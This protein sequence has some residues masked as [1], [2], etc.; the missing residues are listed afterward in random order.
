MQ[1]VSANGI[2]AEA[3]PISPH[4]HT[5]ASAGRRRGSLAL[6]RSIFIPP[7]H[8]STAWR[9][10]RALIALGLGCRL[11]LLPFPGEAEAARVRPEATLP[12]LDP[13][14][15]AF[16]ATNLVDFSPALDPPAGKHGFMFVGSDGRFYFEDGTRGRFWGINVAKDA[17]FVPKEVIDQVAP[18][19]AAAGFNLVR[20]HHVDGITGLLP[21]DRASS[22]D[23]IDPAK[24]DL[25]HY[26]VHALKERG[27]YVYLDL[28]DFRTFQE[29]EGVPHAAELGRGAKPAALFNERL[30]ELQMAYARELLFG[31][32][33]PYTGVALGADPAVVMVEL[34]DENGLFATAPRWAE[35][36][37]PYWTELKR[38]WSFWLRQTYGTT[39]AL[40]RAWVGPDG[41]SALEHGEQLEDS[42]VRLIGPTPPELDFPSPMGGGLSGLA[43]AA[44]QRDVTRFCH[45]VHREYF[46][47]MRHALAQSGLRAPLTA[48]TDWEHPADLRAVVDEL[49]FVGC[50]WYYDH[51]IFAAGRAWHLPSFFTNASPI[52]DQAGL[53]FTSSV[54]KAAAAGKPLVVREWG[55]CWPN[56]LRGAGLVEAAACAAFQDIDALV[57]F[58]YNTDPETR[59]IEYFDVSS[60]PVR[61]GL[62][63]AAGALYRERRVRPAARRAAIA[64][65]REDSFAAPSSSLD[66]L[67]RLGWLSRVRQHLFDDVYSAEGYDVVVAPVQGGRAA[68]PGRRVV[69]HVSR[70]QG[71]EAAATLSLSGYSVAPRLAAEQRFVFDGLVY[72]A[73]HALALAPGLRFATEQLHNAGYEAV[74]VGEDGGLACGFFDP[75]RENCVLADVGAATVLR[76]AA[77]LAAGLNGGGVLRPAHGAFDREEFV[78]DTGEVTRLIKDEQ[79]ILN[80]PRVKAVAG[81]LGGGKLPTSDL[82]INS[83]APL[84]VVIALSLD[85]RP[86]LDSEAFLLKMVTVAANKG[87]K[88]SVRDAPPGSPQLK[89]EAFGT[90]PVDTKGRPASDPTTVRLDGEL[91]LSAYQA[92]GT[93]EAV[94]AGQLWYLW[95]DTPGARF[96]LAGL[97]GAVRVVPFGKSGPGEALSTAQPFVYPADC[98]FVRVG[99]SAP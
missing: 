80:A 54:L 69:F 18:C 77:D 72:D 24:L 74:G 75:R 66:D 20:L 45:S 93:W 92:N 13:N 47:Q 89:L 41:R 43:G 61:W 12:I 36:P 17:V 48:V 86:L 23:R 79:L 49:D 40:R 76:A 16:P 25:V 85:E 38:R 15:A 46:A 27:I 29:D 71:A 7:W 84:G 53:D 78:S 67:F 4:L 98:L 2:A 90:G 31:Q 42:S 60:D 39:E 94:R 21:P 8:R 68:Y 28:L 44:R 95:S 10:T 55:V 50:N 64:S 32:P 11:L 26:W 1:C 3:A 96:S 62:V 59:R 5:T 58:T 30:I 91:V 83:S 37:E 52:A 88:K 33:N 65:S 70:A 34:C 35:M 81:A 87:E 97:A 6:W 73:G 22:E 82:T 14:G 51:P 63:G 19:I 9:A 57:L 56:K 99:S